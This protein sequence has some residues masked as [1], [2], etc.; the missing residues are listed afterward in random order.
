VGRR[1]FR[2]GK[3]LPHHNLSTTSGGR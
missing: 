2:D 1:R 3:E